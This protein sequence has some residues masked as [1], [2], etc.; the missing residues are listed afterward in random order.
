MRIISTGTLKKYWNQPLFRDSEQGLKSW[1]EEVKSGD[2]KS[3][4]DVKA[5]F[6]NASVVA[7]NRVVFNIHGNK[8]RLVVAMKYEFGLCYIRFIGTHEEYDEIDVATV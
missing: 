1:I 7:N 8:Y 4:Q 5:K 3:P 2:W 6:G